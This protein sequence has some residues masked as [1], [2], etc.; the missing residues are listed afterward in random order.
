[1]V[2]VTATMGGV[3]EDWYR[4][5]AILVK[6]GRDGLR[7]GQRPAHRPIARQ[8]PPGTMIW[9]SRKGGWG[10]DGRMAGRAERTEEGATARAVAAPAL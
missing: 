2:K 3:D 9:V 4:Q 7:N 5:R 8:K 6:N 1:M 10:G